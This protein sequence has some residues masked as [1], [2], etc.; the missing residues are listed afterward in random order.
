MIRT[1]GPALI[2][3]SFSSALKYGKPGKYRICTVDVPSAF[4]YTPSPICFVN[5][6]ISLAVGQRKGVADVCKCIGPGLMSVRSPPSRTNMGYN[7]FLRLTDDTQR[8]FA[9]SQRMSALP[10]V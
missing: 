9:S 4:R 2:P 1:S 3:T 7:G 8:N 6:F 10:I 5:P